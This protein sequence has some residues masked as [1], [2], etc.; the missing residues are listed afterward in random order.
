[1]SKEMRDVMLF[2]RQLLREL[3]L[4]ERHRAGPFLLMPRSTTEP[5]KCQLEG[6]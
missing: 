6:T 3:R 1:M 4:N 2:I 5:Y